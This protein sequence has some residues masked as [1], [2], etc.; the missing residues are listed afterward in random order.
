MPI[1]ILIADTQESHR[2]LLSKLASQLGYQF[3][4]ASSADE[5]VEQFCTQHP[6]IVLMDVMMPNIEGLPA[7]G[8][9]K[10]MSTE[11]WVPILSLSAS[12][13]PDEIVPSLKAGADYY[14]TKPVQTEVFHAKLR[15]FERAI[16]TQRELE[17][18]YDKL[19]L[20]HFETQDEKRVANYLMH[21]LINSEGLRTPGVEWWLQPADIFSGDILAAART[22]AGALHLMLADGTG[23]GLTAALSALP[24]PQIFY[25]MTGRGFDIGSIV[26][27]MNR[28]IA[29]FLPVDR[30]FATTLL[31]IDDLDGFI[32]VW[33]GG[34]PDALVV[35][36][37][38]AVI[39][40]FRSQ[41]LPLG[42]DRTE[43]FSTE[44]ERMIFPQGARLQLMMMSDGLLDTL[45]PTSPDHDSIR[46][47]ELLAGVAPEH[48]LDKVRENLVDR[49]QGNLPQD[50]ISILVISTDQ[51]EARSNLQRR[52]APSSSHLPCGA[53]WRFNM[54]L[55]GGQLR[56][57]DKAVIP[58][59]MASVERLYDFKS[60][61]GM[62]YLVISELFDNGLD[63]GLLGLDSRLKGGANGFEIYLAERA[64][65][66]S[67]LDNTASIEFEIEMTEQPAI[68][69]VVRDT[70]PGFDHVAVMQ[71]QLADCGA[72]PYGRGI[73]L[74]RGFGVDLEY[75]G[76]GNE[77]RVHIPLN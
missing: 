3:T 62:L 75:R 41:H 40:T 52:A 33:N 4:F 68:N 8:W 1:S 10:A 44:T 28:R 49:L 36:S 22:P 31:A 60:H 56:R 6:D 72:K 19:K 53:T 46:L 67:E 21:S 24:L 42:V 48:R 30:F 59:V 64:R 18:Q 35:D 45:S 5:V 73:A 55:N 15:N 16:R 65:C 54:E 26:L 50:D 32:E 34:N 58:F 27:E 13:D 77:A 66:L 11:R 37:E 17:K 61:K 43:K 70:G 51:L 63:H 12:S 25:A 23:H 57:M 76:I 20:Y 7:V 9:I 14:I 29:Q 47:M 38:G 71:R 69:L 39:H 2:V 74:I